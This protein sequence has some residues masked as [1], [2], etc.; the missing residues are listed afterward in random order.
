VKIGEVMNGKPAV[1]DSSATF[2]EAARRVAE[3]QASD[4]MVVDAKGVFVGVV[5]EGDLIRAT[6]PNYDELMR[7]GTSLGGAWKVFLEKGKEVASRGIAS[8]VIKAP[9]TFQPADELLKAASAMVNKQ[10]RVLPVVD[11][12]MLVGTISRGDLCKAV[13]GG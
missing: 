1:I 11:G 13:L 3:T 10:I 9:L 5:S 8:I 2:A 12:G 4:L 7:D 6:L